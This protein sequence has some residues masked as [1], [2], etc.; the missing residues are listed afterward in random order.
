MWEHAYHLDYEN[1]RA[2]YVDAWLNVV[3]WDVVE[4]RY[5]DA[6]VPEVADILVLEVTVCSA[7]RRFGEVT[8]DE[9]RQ[10]STELT[11]LAG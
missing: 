9:E 3:N 6:P 8:A 1:R 5:L 11:A 4:Q 7:Q 10:H 2:E